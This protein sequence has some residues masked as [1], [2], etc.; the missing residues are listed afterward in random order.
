[1]DCR[2]S[3]HWN[4]G[5]AD[6]GQFLFATIEGNEENRGTSAKR[7]C[8]LNSMSANIEG[9]SQLAQDHATGEGQLRLGQNHRMYR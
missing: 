8:N 3:V 5:G 7:E 4:P 9:W 2:P 6:F 1:M